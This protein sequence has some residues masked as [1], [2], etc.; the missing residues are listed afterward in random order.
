MPV[1]HFYTRQ[2]C[3]L[4][5]LMLEA[6]LPMLRGR[7]ELEC[8]DIDSDPV[9]REKYDTR[10]PVLEQDGRLICQYE[11]DPGAVVSA[12]VQYTDSGQ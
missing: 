7:A 8:R 3:H 10:V 6:L 11:L 5:E 4:C 9:W 1:F 12:L 2:G